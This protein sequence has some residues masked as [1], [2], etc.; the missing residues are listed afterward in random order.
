LLCLPSSG[1]FRLEAAD[2]LLP[3]RRGSRL[4]S[5]MGSSSRDSPKDKRPRPLTGVRR[6]PWCSRARSLPESRTDQRNDV[7]APAS[8][9]RVTSPQHGPRQKAPAWGRGFL[10]SQLTDA[11][12]ASRQVHAGLAGYAMKQRS[13]AIRVPFSRRLSHPTKS[14]RCVAWRNSLFIPT[15]RAAPLPKLAQHARTRTLGSL[16]RSSRR[17]R[18][19]G[20]RL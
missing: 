15:L 19:K 6:S 18:R 9:Q 7:S 4:A 8:R 10:Y 5:H 13:I 3:G 17:S 14:F 16:P 1:R 12:S 2:Q 11:T 20:L